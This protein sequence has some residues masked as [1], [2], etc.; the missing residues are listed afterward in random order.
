MWC[1]MEAPPEM[2]GIVFC[3]S[4]YQKAFK[5]NDWPTCVA[6]GTEQTFIETLRTGG[7]SAYMEAIKC[8]RAHLGPCALNAYPV[9]ALTAYL[10]CALL[11]SAL[12][13]M[14]FGCYNLLSNMETTTYEPWT[15]WPI[16][17]DEVSL[18]WMLC[19]QSYSNSECPA[20]WIHFCTSCRFCLCRRHMRSSSVCCWHSCMTKMMSHLLLLKRYAMLLEYC[21]LIHQIL[22]NST[23]F[24]CLESGC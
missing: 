23:E 22:K 4:S 10:L 7:S 12:C 20:I 11:C 24:E 19:T 17:W 16:L 21:N 9:C 18:E 6:C 5:L 2:L 14:F 1:G 15:R 8:S 13:P 3:N